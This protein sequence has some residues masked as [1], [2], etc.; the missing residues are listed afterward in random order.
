MGQV[1]HG[2]ATTTEAV[3][4]PIQLRQESVRL[5]ALRCERDDGSEVAQQVETADA[6]MGPKEPRP[7][8]QVPSCTA[9]NPGSP[10]WVVHSLVPGTRLSF[11]I[12]RPI[13]VLA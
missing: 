13:P 4:R 5:Q 9:D 1:L 2:S 6:P 3:H 10:R 11:S 12:K 7:G 8:R